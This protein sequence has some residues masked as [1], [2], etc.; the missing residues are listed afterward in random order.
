MAY[1]EE[2]LVKIITKIYIKEIFIGYRA[3]IKVILDRN[4]RF[5]SSDPLELGYPLNPVTL[6]NW[7]LLLWKLSTPN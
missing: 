3:P 4:L 1:I 5:I 7:L 2:I 6:P